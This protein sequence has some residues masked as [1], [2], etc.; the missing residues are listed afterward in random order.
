VRRPY[1]RGRGHH[2][3]GLRRVAGGGPRLSALRKAGPG[4][5]DELVTLCEEFCLVDGHPF[6]R[7]RITAAL[8]PLLADDAHGEVWVVPGDDGLAGYAVITWGYSIEAG[9]HDVRLDE[10]YLR[11]QGFGTGTVLL[12]QLIARAR[13]RG[14][15][16]IFLET[17]MSNTAARRFY[18]RHGFSVDD[19]V[20]MYLD[21]S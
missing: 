7:D 1:R 13:E 11:E 21:L 3:A 19:S 5:F 17:E 4:D 16:S 8:E 15:S 6:D 9:G 18:S 14:A 10:I 12:E 20:W 2:I